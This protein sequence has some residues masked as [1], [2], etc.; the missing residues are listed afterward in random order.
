MTWNLEIYWYQSCD[1]IIYYQHWKFGYREILLSEL[2]Q[3]GL[4]II[5]S[6]LSFAYL[7]YSHANPI[8]QTG[9]LFLEIN[10]Y[11]SVEIK[12]VGFDLRTISLDENPPS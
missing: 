8:T 10:L 11:K 2:I 1:N 3:L 9:L 12:Y 6:S 5:L 4:Y 7:E